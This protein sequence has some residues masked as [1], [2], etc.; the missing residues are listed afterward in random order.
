MG[1]SGLALLRRLQDYRPSLSYGV[2]KGQRG[3]HR[4]LT[5]SIP[6]LRR[7]ADDTDAL[8]VGARFVPQRQ[9][10]AMGIENLQRLGENRSGRLVRSEG[11]RQG[12]H[13]CLQAGQAIRRL[14]G[15]PACLPLGLVQILQSGHGPLLFSLDPPRSA[16]YFEQDSAGFARSCT[17]RCSAAGRRTLR[18]MPSMLGIPML[19]T[20]DGSTILKGTVPCFERHNIA[21]RL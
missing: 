13:D 21:R 5:P 1:V 10:T 18:A 15:G 3:V 8:E 20:G 17:W 2:S 14:F 7:V 6:D 19:E 12:R 11:V 9:D 4:Q 16:G